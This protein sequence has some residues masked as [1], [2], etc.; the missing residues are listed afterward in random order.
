MLIAGMGVYG[1]R[2]GPAYENQGSVPDEWANNPHILEWWTDEHDAVV[3][4][5]L[6][7][8]KW[9][10]FWKVTDRLVDIIP[11]N[12]LDQWQKADRLCRK[13]AWYNVLMNFAQARA[14]VMGYL[15]E[16][17]APQRKKCPLCTEDFTENSLGMPFVER[18]GADK[19]DICSPCLEAAIFSDG[20]RY[21]DPQLIVEF[22][23]EL[24][25]IVERVPPQRFGEG[26]HDLRDL[27]TE[28]RVRLLRHF[29]N[30]PTKESV[31]RYF[32]TWFDALVAADLLDDGAR[33]NSRGIQCHAEDGHMCHSLG[34]KTID[35]L[36][37]RKGVSHSR[38][39][40]YPES[41]YR[42]DF[43]IAGTF[44]EYFGLAGNADYDKKAKTKIRLAKK[45]KIPLVAIYPKDL[46]ST[47]KLESKLAK[48][49]GFEID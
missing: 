24:A 36:L 1:K 22:L 31:K 14:Q 10:W 44:I 12:A 5:T 40:K 7:E 26:V 32:N 11:Q 49:P 17:P 27:D 47:K 41:N 21:N 39:P 9:N 43:E 45:H 28:T 25:S 34:E 15:A 48:V 18:L 33:K 42:G 35:D 6:A 37:F 38:E 3:L 19:I 13:Y 2:I 16:V 29:S 20:R 8:W 4:Q 30:K 46:V 23:C